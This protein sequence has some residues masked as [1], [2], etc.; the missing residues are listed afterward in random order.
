M[1]IDPLAQTV[2][3]IM[4]IAMLL[5]FTEVLPLH[6]T[7]ILIAFLLIVVAGYTPTETFAP[8]F[9][10]VVVLLMGGF[11]LARAMQKHK[12]DEYIAMKFLDR[13]GH[14]PSKFLLGIMI[15]SA[16]LSMWM[17]NTASA[18]ILLPIALVILAK[19]Q[20]KP[21]KSN[22]GKALV[23]GIAFSATVGGIGS[24]VGSTPNVIA[25]KFLNEAG[26]SFG[27]T[28]WM[29]YGLPFVVIFIPIMWVVLTRVF[30]SE[31]TSLKKIEFN[32]TLNR[33][34][35]KILIIFA[36]TALLWLTTKFHGLASSTVALVPIIA[37]YVF[38][39]LDTED[40]AKINWAVLILI[41]GGLSLGLA[42]Q[43]SG[44]D[45][46]IASLIETSII[47][48]PM[49][50]I[51]VG[52]A[53]FAILLTV[54]ASNTAA[55]AVMIP[56]MIPLAAALGLPIT[57]IVMIAAIGVSLDFIVPVGTPPSAIAYSSGY[58]RVKDMAK[59]GLILAAIG[60]I[61]LSGLAMLYW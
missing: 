15:V 9:D 58:V 33:Y 55:G 6:A 10:P 3:A 60:V 46:L 24:L 23:L 14:S 4:I 8:F 29:Y 36:A 53:L 7:A 47:A 57:P 22:Y 16:F 41:G 48:Q 39:L 43:S 35:K 28:D 37:L 45:I 19:N 20:I 12:L 27:F 11:V 31:I 59:V 5:W 61:L 34:Q 13:F 50:I 17:S 32:N 25:A 56:L 54:V 49:F 30:K 1:G 2:L 21:L 42:I 44:L 18:A 38:G 40:F 51:F 52:L 26:I